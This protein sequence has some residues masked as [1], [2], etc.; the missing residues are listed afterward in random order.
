MS[1]LRQGP[2]LNSG[3][4]DLRIDLSINRRKR[5]EALGSDPNLSSACSRGRGTKSLDGV[6]VDLISPEVEAAWREP[7][8]PT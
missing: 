3:K 8:R 2:Q 5:T 1:M 4:S 7:L 6:I